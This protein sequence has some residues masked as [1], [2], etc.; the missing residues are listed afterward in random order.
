V[1]FEV[2]FDLFDISGRPWHEAVGEVRESLQWQVLKTITWWA[3]DVILMGCG[4]V[5]GCDEGHRVWC[6][7]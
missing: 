3:Q 1:V 4:Q 5:E 7:K 6:L 2:I